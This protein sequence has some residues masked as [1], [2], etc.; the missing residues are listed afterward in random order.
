MFMRDFEHGDLLSCSWDRL[1]WA[2]G[3]FW[4]EDMDGV[5]HQLSAG[6]NGEY[7]TVKVPDFIPMKYK[8]RKLGRLTIWC[9][10]CELVTGIEAHYAGRILQFI[11]D[12]DHFLQKAV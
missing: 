8:G 4:K 6:Y 2:G 3:D 1:L 5:P 11:P 9:N 10:S 7:W 12:G